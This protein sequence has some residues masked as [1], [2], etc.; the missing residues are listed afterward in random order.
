MGPLQGFYKH[1]TVYTYTHTSHTH[2]HTH[3][4]RF[5]FQNIKAIRPFTDNSHKTNSYPYYKERRKCEQF[6]A[7]HKHAMNKITH[8]PTA[9][10]WN[11]YNVE[12]YINEKRLK[13]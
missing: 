12:R 8:K 6:I 7:L 9:K 11:Q 10:V 4:L 3:T 13:N 5:K 1:F 2:T